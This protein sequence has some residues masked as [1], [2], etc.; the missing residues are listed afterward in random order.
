[1]KELT[2]FELNKAI[3]VLIFPNNIFIERYSPRRDSV[4]VSMKDEDLDNLNTEYDYCNN[5]NDLM[6]AI[7]KLDPDIHVNIT[8][9]GNEVELV[10]NGVSF[11]AVSAYLKRALAETLLK[12]L[13]GEQANE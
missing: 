13:Q 4:Y 5:W 6:N 1:M 7:D 2:D 9:Q 11:N 10:V 12:V 3:A 8:Y